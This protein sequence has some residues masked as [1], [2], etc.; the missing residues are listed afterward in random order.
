MPLLDHLRLPIDELIRWGSFHASWATR[1]ADQLTP[2]VPTDFVVEESSHHAG[3]LEIDVASYDRKPGSRAE[4]DPWRSEWH[5]PAPDKTGPLVFPDRYEVKVFNLVGGRRLVAAI[6]FV[7]PGNKDRAAERLAFATKCANYLHNG[8]G[9]I[10]ID[11]VTD[12]KGNLHNETVRLMQADPGLAMPPSADLYA[13]S[14][15]PVKRG[16]RTE[17]DLWYHTFQIG[18]PLPTLPLRLVGDYFVPVDFEAAYTEA[19]R[20]RRLI[21]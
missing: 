19:C 6:E 1:I 20:R 16:D 11:V 14:Y 18:D 4:D 17:L 7:S 13:V 3:G 15:R 8:V 21:P 5:P 12:R 9:L 2:L 10:V